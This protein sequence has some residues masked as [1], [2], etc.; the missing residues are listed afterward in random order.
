MG[1][2][3]HVPV[4]ERGFGEIAEAVHNKLSAIQWG[5]E[6]HPWSVKINDV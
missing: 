6:E 5:N 1:R 3:I 2:D 4:T